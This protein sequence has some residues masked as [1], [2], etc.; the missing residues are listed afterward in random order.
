MLTEIKAIIDEI[1][2]NKQNGKIAV[3]K[4]LLL[5][6]IFKAILNGSDNSFKFKSIYKNLEDLMEKYGWGTISKKKAEYPFYFLASSEIWEI[7]I[8]KSDLKHPDSPSKLEMENAVG[9]LNDRIYAFLSKNP[10]ELE[11]LIQHVSN[12]YFG[13]QIDI[14]IN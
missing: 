4:P 9:K 13:K 7:N 14:K 11:S 8:A 6:I 3:Y 10:H 5:L 1:K 12:K 2:V